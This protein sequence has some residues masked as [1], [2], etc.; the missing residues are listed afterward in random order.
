MG[1]KGTRR[2]TKIGEPVTS[3]P[4]PIAICY[5][6]IFGSAPEKVHLEAFNVSFLRSDVEKMIPPTPLRPLLR[7]IR[8][9]LNLH[10]LA[11][12]VAAQNT[13]SGRIYWSRSRR[14]SILG[15][16][17]PKNQADIERAMHQWITDHDYS[18]GETP[19]R[20]RAQKLW[21]LIAKDGN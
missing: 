4:G 3:T 2:C 7:R 13:N 9:G 11:I 19:I 15:D 16:L 17:K 6:A 5:T 1:L 20:E 12:R 8:P 14:T 18:A 21:Q 10:Q